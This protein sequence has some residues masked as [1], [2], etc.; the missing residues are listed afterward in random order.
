M[1]Y[2][3]TRCQLQYFDN[4]QLHA[5]LRPCWA[6]LPSYTAVSDTSQPNKPFAKVIS[7]GN[8][9]TTYVL[10]IACQPA[11]HVMG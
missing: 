5:L 2:N 3:C 7:A 8:H 10:C 9:G 6:A 4:M 11:C 1:A